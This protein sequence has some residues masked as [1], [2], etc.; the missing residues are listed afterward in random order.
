[1][2]LR[3]AA[4][5]LAAASTAAALQDPAPPKP[6]REHD[7]L[8]HL[9]GERDCTSRFV[10]APGQ[11]PLV[12]KGKVLTEQM[13]DADPATGK[14]MTMRLVREVRDADRRVLTFFMPGP[15]GKEVQAGTIEYTRR[16][17]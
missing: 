17:K 9:A 7:C 10:M 16:K 3:L 15:D 1:M 13:Q 5:L 2:T 4:L 11:E 12:S 14:P 8:K 6:G